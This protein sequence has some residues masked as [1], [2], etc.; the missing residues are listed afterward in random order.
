MQQDLFHSKFT[1]YFKVEARSLS[2]SYVE[3]TWAWVGLAV[4]VAVIVVGVVFFLLRNR[5]RYVRVVFLFRN[6]YR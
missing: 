4:S 3:D 6:I 5:Y 2:V 1:H